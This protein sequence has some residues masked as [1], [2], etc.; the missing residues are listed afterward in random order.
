MV[1]PLLFGLAGSALGG[2]G[3]AGGLGALTAGAIGSGLG[4]FAETGDLGKGIETG[5]TS[6][7]GGKA[8][9]TL[10]KVAGVESLAKAGELG[11]T[12]PAV[13]TVS[14]TITGLGTLTNPA[15]L[16]QAAIGQA[17]VPPP[18]PPPVAPVPFENR[19]AGVPDR[20]TR[21]PPKGYR[22]GYDAEFD[23]GVSPNFGVGLMNPNDPRYMNMG[24]LLGLLQ[25]EKVQDNLSNMVGITLNPAVQREI[26]NAMT[27]EYTPEGYA[28]LTMA[29]AGFSG[30]GEL[31]EIP[32]DN[33]GL[34]AL[35]KEK[36]SV[37]E[38]MGF[39]A[40][41]EG[42]AV[43]GDMEANK[44]IDDAVNAIKGLSDSPEIALGL[45]V[46]KYGEEALEDLIERVNDGE[47]D[48]PRENNMIEGEGDGMD[49][50]VPATLEGEQ[51]VM[52]S[53]GEFVVPAD[54]VSGIGN[55]SSDAGARELEDMMTR[56]RQL[57]TGKKE[58]PKQVPQ[59]MMLPV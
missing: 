51:D 8:L 56:V 16:G 20:I 9:G 7:L 1:L 44:I 18:M 45:F 11:T 31:K 49:D 5:L 3:L 21:R 32:E 59:E 37:V 23:Y 19:Q 6:F 39:K 33:K 46:A 17:T 47:F 42:G 34:K 22:P 26:N 27:G 30:G 50:K 55:G 35:A 58:Q 36:P 43:E 13:Q 41:Q 2:A 25:N 14:P 52:L 29:D 15:V 38:N 24:G 12:P 28:P 40:M 57:R 48:Q 10:G 53:D 54:V 4:R